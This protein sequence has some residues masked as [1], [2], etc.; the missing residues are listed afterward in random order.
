M[1]WMIPTV[2]YDYSGKGK[3]M[4]I[5]KRSVVARVGRKNEQIEHGVFQGSET[6]FVQYNGGQVSLYILPKPIEYTTP[7]MYP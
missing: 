2:I 3:T 7:R 6:I 5:V 1:Y 4:E